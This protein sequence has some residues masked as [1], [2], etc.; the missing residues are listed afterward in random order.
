MELTPQDHDLR[1]DSPWSIGERASMLLLIVLVPA[2]LVLDLASGRGVAMHLFYLIPVTLAA[3]T[4]GSRAGY[5]V[6]G[7][8][9]AAWA[10]VAVS[11]RGSTDSVPVIACDVLS[12]F[13]MLM[14]VA[15]LVARHRG[16]VDA[17]RARARVDSETGALSRREFDQLLDAEARRT[18]R[19]RRPMALVVFDLGEPKG[20]R[21]GHI[22]A[23]ARSLRGHVRDCDCV[24]RIAPR[25]FA[26]LLVEC[27][28]PEHMLV[29]ERLR[30]ALVAD[31]RLHKDDFAVAVATYKGSLPVSAASF[32]ALAENHLRLARSSAGV[33]ETRVD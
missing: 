2:V 10:Y 11:E 23:V 4:L 18:R 20:E 24:S 31:L 6:A 22:R 14:F 27:K 28:A 3:W 9:G 30:D 25:R 29:V 7:A 1:I 8:A 15:H 32:L 21:P 33:A 17:I 19:Y 16:L 5:A 26:I 13:A 12:T